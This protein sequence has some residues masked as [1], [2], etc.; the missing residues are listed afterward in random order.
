[1][2]FPSGLRNF[3]N[4]RVKNAHQT[5]AKSNSHQES[6]SEDETALLSTISLPMKPTT[7]HLTKTRH[8][9]YYVNDDHSYRGIRSWRNTTP[10]EDSLEHPSE[11][12]VAI[13]HQDEALHHD[14][15]SPLTDIQA[16]LPIKQLQFDNRFSQ[17]EQF[18]QLHS[19]P[20]SQEETQPVDHV[21]YIENLENPLI[22]TIVNRPQLNLESLDTSER[23]QSESLLKPKTFAESEEFKLLKQDQDGVK[24]KHQSS[25]FFAKVNYILT[26]PYRLTVAI[27]THIHDTGLYFFKAISTI[28]T[29]F[30]NQVRRVS[31]SAS[32]MTR[33]I[34]SFFGEVL[35]LGWAIVRMFINIFAE[36]GKSLLLLFGFRRNTLISKQDRKSS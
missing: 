16:A 31:Q 10:V 20:Q 36:S 17:L 5:H 23:I 35:A 29:A 25:G 1:M 22:K 3:L 14:T 21:E 12:D 28:F 19:I 26:S 15:Y 13:T 27:L 11:E 4:K 24:D 7:R 34:S 2:A 32:R 8:S 30:G 6:S 33:A 9:K 18:K